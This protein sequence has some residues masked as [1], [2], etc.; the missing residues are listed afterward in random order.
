MILE[1]T[2]KIALY[3]VLTALALILSFVESQIP[4]FVAIPGMKIGLTN[5]VV[6][7]AL[8]A[9]GDKI[10]LAINI[11]RILLVS[12]LFG[13]AMSLGFSL[14]GGF[15]S[16]LVMV[17]LKRTEKFGIIGV[18]C[19]GAVSHNIGQILVAMFIMNTGAIAL[20]LPI[21]WATGIA[22]GIVIGL[23]GGIIVRRI[24]LS[25]MM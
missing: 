14:A 6:I 12:L 7:F 17:L 15:L 13:N 22:S 8:Y 20:Y 5:I 23:I 3:G 2:K 19:A 18:S 21:L 4:A 25:D 11:V 9:I 10:A 24:S 1:K 16:Y